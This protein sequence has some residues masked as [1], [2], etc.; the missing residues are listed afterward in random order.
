M[1]R[2]RRD[3][4]IRPARERIA[5]AFWDLLAQMP[6]RDITM[7]AV[8]TRAGVNHNTFYYHFAN[9]EALTEQMIDEN[10]MA[11]MP[12]RMLGAAAKP[13]DILDEVVK[14]PEAYRRF[15]R[16]C[17]LVG[18]HSTQ[19]LVERLKCQTRDFWLETFGIDPACLSLAD[20]VTLE[21]VIGGILSLLGTY[22]EKAPNAMRAFVEEGRL[23]QT[24]I[25]SLADITR[26]H[27][28]KQPPA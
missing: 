7:K 27:S 17:L 4:G 11:D 22:G 13:S 25:E 18:P 5:D 20:E 24:L 26:R 23:F 8:A 21:F 3:S 19:K 9:L 6:Y 2:P 16:M 14:S 15:E 28:S 12:V 10:F 1:A